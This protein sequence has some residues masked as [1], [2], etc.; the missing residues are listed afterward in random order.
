VHLELADLDLVDLDL[1]DLER[2]DLE[3][4]HLELADL[5]EHQL[6]LLE[7]VDFLVRY[8]FRG[9]GFNSTVGSECLFGI[10][11]VFVL[12]GFCR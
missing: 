7:T 4:T 11:G 12:R 1:V 8:A 2:V 3:L 6:V 5:D 10:C 9:D